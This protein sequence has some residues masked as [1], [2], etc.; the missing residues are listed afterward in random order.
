V[1]VV[2]L[3][4]FLFF[5][6]E[7]TRSITR[8]RENESAHMRLDISARNGN[9]KKGKKKGEKP[10]LPRGREGEQE[11][12]S[13]RIASAALFHCVVTSLMTPFSHTRAR[14]LALAPQKRAARTHF[15]ARIGRADVVINER[16]S[17]SGLNLFDR[18]YIIDRHFSHTMDL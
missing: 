2:A 9:E 12:K 7:S 10:P 11:G 13:G 15:R 14:V 18:H 16:A 4:P 3:L 5:L 1:R 17:A 6:I 8:L